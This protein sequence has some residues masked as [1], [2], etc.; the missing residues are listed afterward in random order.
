MSASF[1]LERY[2]VLAGTISEERASP[3]YKLLRP[4]R[5]PGFPSLITD[6]YDPPGAKDLN[7]EFPASEADALSIRPMGHMA[8]EKSKFRAAEHAGQ[9]PKKAMWTAVNWF[10]ILWESASDSALME[11]QPRGQSS[12]S[13]HWP[14]RH[15][16]SQYS[17]KSG[18]T[19]D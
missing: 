10:A 2:L 9:H 8:E 5:P 11:L 4:I 12:R 1:A 7:L 15:T 19:G 17:G 13:F 18:H 14:C 6:K 16:R 3:T